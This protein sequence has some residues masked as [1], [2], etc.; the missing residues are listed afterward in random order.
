L[1]AKN[2]LV[3]AVAGAT[4]LLPA[5]KKPA[6]AEKKKRPAAEKTASKEK[7]RAT[8]PWNQSEWDIV[9]PRH[10]FPHQPPDVPAP[11]LARNKQPHPPFMEA[12]RK[13]VEIAKR[14]NVDLVF[15]GDSITEKWGEYP[16]L[17]NADFGAC[18][19]ANFGIGGDR[20]QHVLWR[21]A[22]GELDGIQPKVAVVM[23]GTNN[24]GTDPAEEVA[25]GIHRIVDLILEKSPNSKILLMGILPRGESPNPDRDLI[26]LANVEIAKLQNGQNIVFQDIGN[27][28]LRGDGTM[29]AELMPDFNHPSEAGCRV[30]AEAIKPQL[31]EWMK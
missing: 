24:I 14:G 19:P 16:E 5:C 23:I 30:W 13:F 4:L 28:Y 12:H 26:K 3:A 21:I 29:P 31:E 6:I 2:A 17:W 11:K 27:R 15:F 9:D 25:S 22:N 18:R 8:P 10:E 1:N 7:V 20:T